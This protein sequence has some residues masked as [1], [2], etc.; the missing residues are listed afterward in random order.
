MRPAN[1]LCPQNVSPTN[2]RRVRGR[3]EVAPPKTRQSVERPCRG[4]FLVTAALEALSA[5]AARSVPASQRLHRVGQA[6]ASNAVR[7]SQRLSAAPVDGP[8]SKGVTVSPNRSVAIRGISARGGKSLRSSPIEQSVTSVPGCGS[9]WGR[10]A[11][12]RRIVRGGAALSTVAKAWT[13]GLQQR[14]WTV[15]L[16]SVARLRSAESVGLTIGRLT[17]RFSGRQGWPSAIPAAAE[18]HSR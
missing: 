12:G 6:V 15:A 13:V 14:G 9:L 8:A 16:Q 17:R 2:C 1:A 11:R 18:L 3:G 7:S 10:G 5:T 4:R